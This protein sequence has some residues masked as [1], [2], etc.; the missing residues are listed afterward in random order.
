MND[1]QLA[2]QAFSETEA[3]QNKSRYYKR[4]QE[5]R[6][7]IETHKTIENWYILQVET[8]KQANIYSCELLPNLRT[9]PPKNHFIH[10]DYHEL[11]Q[12]HHEF[13]TKN[14]GTEGVKNGQ[15]FSQ[16]SWECCT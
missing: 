14:T 15:N 12:A 13:I 7:I 3:M 8:E 6:K 11:S 5:I 9:L 1:N 2:K 16:N 4:N 10:K